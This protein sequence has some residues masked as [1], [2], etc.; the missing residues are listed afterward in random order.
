MIPDFLLDKTA[1]RFPRFL[2]DNIRIESLEKGGSD[3][4]YYRIAVREESSLILV[5]YGD[6]REENR[7]YCEIDAFL[8]TIGVRVPTIY[9]HDLEAGL[10]WMEDLGEVDLWQFRDEAWSVRRPLYLD[11]IEQ[12]VRLHT[13]GHLPLE[14]GKNRALEGQP[15]QDAMARDIPNPAAATSIPRFQTAFDAQL[16]RWEQNYF[17]DNCVA[18]YFCVDPAA[19]E[20]KA[21]RP[22]LNEIAAILAAQP[23]VLIHRDFQ[24]QNI[25]VQHEYAYLIDFQG[26]RPGLGQYDLASLLYDPYVRLTASERDSLLGDY[27]VLCA[28]AGYAVP[29]NFRE[30]YDLC[31]MQR[32]M[33]ALGAYGFL[34][35]VKDRSSFLKHIP[36][37]LA[38]LREVATRIP[39]IDNLRSLLDELS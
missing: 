15:Q 13:R 31:A 17:F 26:M 30:I 7:H 18:R 25:M 2:R 33:Q 6:Q 28:E 37:A 29:S 5:K 22:R 32:L 9:H 10:I 38:S 27:I 35:L 39:G 14:A 23:R 3:R 36:T 19:I 16:Y 12:V 1:H 34:G 11:A 20:A 24:S 8:K 4:K 21:D